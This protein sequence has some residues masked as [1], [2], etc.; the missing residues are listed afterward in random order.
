M[1]ADQLK[2]EADRLNGTWGSASGAQGFVQD[3]T[4]I[5]ALAVRDANRG[6]RALRVAAEVA[7]GEKGTIGKLTGAAQ[8]GS[9]AKLASVSPRLAGTAGRVLGP[10]L[11]GTGKVLGALGRTAPFISLPFA[12]IDIY[13][14]VA[15][16]D[17]RKKR[18]AIA[19]AG[20]SVAGTAAGFAGV[21]LLAT[22]FGLP[23]VGLSALTGGYQLF[24]TFVTKGKGM[25]FLGRHVVKPLQGLFRRQP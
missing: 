9:A 6:A 16:K 21:A 3:S 23:L 25:D 2:Q 5:S 10:A 4:R 13:D 11:Q 24:D 8:A 19:N 20:F 22:P 1:T 7:A 12:G 15:E 18:G 17:P 14:A